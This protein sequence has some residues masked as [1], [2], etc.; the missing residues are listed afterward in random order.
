MSQEQTRKFTSQSWNKIA[1]FIH[2][3]WGKIHSFINLLLRKFSWN[4]SIG[5]GKIL[6]V[7]YTGG[8]ITKFCQLFPE[9][10]SEIRQL[11]TGKYNGFCHSVTKIV[12]LEAGK[13]LWISLIC[14]MKKQWKSPIGC[15]KN[16]EICQLVAVK[17][18]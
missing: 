16:H 2:V 17:K 15:S 7:S 14:C 11:V 5:H 9:K 10:N 1:K 4:L 6:F 8:N 12:Q 18:M 13:Q 3:F